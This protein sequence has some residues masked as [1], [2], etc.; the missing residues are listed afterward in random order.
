MAKNFQNLPMEDAK[1]LAESPTGQQLMQLLRQSGGSQLDEA[2]KQLQ[3]GNA[4]QA[5]E[6]LLPLME[7]PN[8]RALLRQLGG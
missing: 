3:Q 1:H 6:L 4:A 5:M 7:D 2:A 8:I